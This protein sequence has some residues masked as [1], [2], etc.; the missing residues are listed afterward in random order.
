MTHK[1]LKRL[2]Y[3]PQQL[4]YVTNEIEHA[5]TELK[6]YITSDS[7]QGSYAVEPYSPHAITISGISDT[8]HYYETRMN[9]AL[10]KEKRTYY[11]KEIA[12]LKEYINSVDDHQIKAIME[13]YY[14]KHHS[15]QKIALSYNCTD[16]SMPRKKVLRYLQHARFARF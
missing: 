7:V 2:R 6:G 12:R 1:E 3:F 9:L 13:R 8:K 15:W 11:E 4:N 10:L 16:E 5:E 14:I